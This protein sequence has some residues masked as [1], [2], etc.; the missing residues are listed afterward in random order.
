[1]FY[2]NGCLDSGYIFYENYSLRK[3]Y[4]KAL[5]IVKDQALSFRA[6]SKGFELAIMNDSNEVIFDIYATPYLTPDRREVRSKIYLRDL[7]KEVCQVHKIRDMHVKN[8]CDGNC[9]FC[10]YS[11]RIFYE[12][13]DNSFNIGCDLEEV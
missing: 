3:V 7:T 6:E 2:F 13:L 8:V 11:Y 12:N 1:M 5:D 9:E 4:E 10:K